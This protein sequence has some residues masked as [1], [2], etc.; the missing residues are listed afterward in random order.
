MI[1]W[2]Y[3]SERLEV[4]RKYRGGMPPSRN[5]SG[6]FKVTGLLDDASLLDVLIRAILPLVVLPIALLVALFLIDRVV[7][8]ADKRSRPIDH[9]NPIFL[10]GN[11]QGDERSERAA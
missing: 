2:A 10:A 7:A 4:W 3:L 9:P 1:R 11:R 5:E 8:F 6:E